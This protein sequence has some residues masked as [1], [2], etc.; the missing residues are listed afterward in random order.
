M[1]RKSKLTPDQW[2]TIDTRVLEGESIR[3]L[4]R[5]F[6]VTDSTIRERIAK[7]GKIKS[8]QI[9]AQ[10]IID[11]ENS[12]AA[13]PITARITAQ[14]L[15]AKLRAISDNL[16]SAAQYGAQNA[17]RLHA[18]ANGQLQQLDDVEP[19]D[20]GGKGDQILRNVAVLT[21][22]AN[23]ASQVGVDLIKANRSIMEER[24]EDKVALDPTTRA[25]RL[26]QILRLNK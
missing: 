17:H 10:K 13:L 26:V 15:A 20:A 9:V 23:E 24:P 18:I 5:E 7:H 2:A 1:G 8:V 25:A 19:M 3:A 11:A 21:K 4:A 6:G 12:L 22:V 14:N 16:T